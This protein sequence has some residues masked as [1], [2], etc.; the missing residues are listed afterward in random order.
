[1]HRLAEVLRMLIIFAVCATANADAPAM[2]IGREA[3]RSQP[4]LPWYDA[5]RDHERAVRMRSVPE[6]PVRHSSWQSAPDVSRPNTRARPSGLSAMARFMQIL[7]WGA[8]GALLFGLVILLAWAFLRARTKTVDQP[9]GTSVVAAS[10]DRISQLPM[11]VV[12][13]SGNLLETARMHRQAG[14]LPMAI[15]FLFAHL[16][17]ELDRHQLIRLSR[18]K[19]N[20][21]YLGELQTRVS[22]RGGGR[23]QNHA[24]PQP[25]SGRPGANTTAGK[26]TSLPEVTPA[27][28][29]VGILARTMTAYEDVFFGRHAISVQRSDECWD[30][31][32]EFEHQLEHLV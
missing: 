29:V 8:V 4:E 30:G 28:A 6:D 7:T 21:Q 11:P 22:P 16:L 9:P 31:L 3:L 2:D 17:F 13:T 18:G 25:S 15:I 32:T 23:P 1:M 5:D 12:P 27:P 10:P 24:L 19:T 26:S 20:R 14:E